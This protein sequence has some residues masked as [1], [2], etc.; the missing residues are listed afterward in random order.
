MQNLF[1]AALAGLGT[2]AVVMG[3][4]TGTGAGRAA[5]KREVPLVF[6]G[7]H[8]IG[9]NDYGR[10]VP[11]IAAALGVTP[12]QFRAAFA[13]VTPAK[14]RG[15]TG[16][17]A[18][19]N[20]AA[21]MKVLG[22]LGVTNERLDEVSNHYRF[23]PQEGELWTNTPAKGYAVVEGGKIEKVVVTEP[24]SG[25]STLPKVTIQGMEGVALKATLH[26]DRDLR[27]NGSIASVEPAAPK[28]AR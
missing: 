19:K 22:P 10:P 7:G 3:V 14:G 28:P 20:K 9:R 5:E 26:L 11:L 23:Q 27:K 25:Y 18:R 21:L 12:D 8:E 4:M 17:E 1:N 15:P 13:G 16:A 2:L 24:G 6:S